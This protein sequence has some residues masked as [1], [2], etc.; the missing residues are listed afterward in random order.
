MKE[1][2]VAHDTFT[3]ERVYATA[4]QRVFAAFSDPAVKARWF[5]GPSEWTV[6]RALFEFRVGGRERVISKPHSGPAHRF[7][8][9]YLDIV[10]DQRIVYTY[11]MHMDDTLTSISV[12]TFEF[13]PVPEGARLVLTEQGAFLDGHDRPGQREAGTRGLL[14]KLAK[15]L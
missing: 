7:D 15:A 11:T 13:R 6:D 1:R 4:P 2:T 10:A 5:A 8:A 3:L 14:E 12:A 9:T